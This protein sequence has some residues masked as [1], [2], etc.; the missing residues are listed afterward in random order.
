MFACVEKR[1]MEK[2]AWTDRDTKRE[3]T[4]RYRDS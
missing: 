2:Y 3:R 4:D 1:D